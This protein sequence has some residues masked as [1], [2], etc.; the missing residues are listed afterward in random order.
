M[1]WGA[2][3]G[4]GD[5]GATVTSGHQNDLG[6]ADLVGRI[7]GPEDVGRASGGGDPDERV[8]RVGEGMELAGE[9]RIKTIIVA[10]GGEGAAVNGQGQTWQRFSIMNETTGQFRGKMLGVSGASSIPS[11]E[12]LTAV[13]ENPGKVLADPGD[14]RFEVFR[15]PAVELGGFHQM[16]SNYGGWGRGHFGGCSSAMLKPG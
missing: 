5:V 13:A 9:H 1:V 11:D 6:T 4:I 12:D 2:R 10:D 3:V 16:I 8:T 14:L 15:N 7:D